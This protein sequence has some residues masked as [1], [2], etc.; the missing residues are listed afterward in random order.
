MVSGSFSG[1]D[2]NGDGVLSSTAGEI[3]GFTMN[4]SVLSGTG[5]RMNV[6]SLGFTDL[7]GLSYQIGNSASF[8]VVASAPGMGAYLG[9]VPAIPP[10]QGMA[11]RDGLMMVSVA[12][13]QIAAVAEPETYALMLAGLGLVG[14]MARRHKTI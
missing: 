3:T 14:F 1:V 2:S 12:P 9:G 11:M 4:Y 10:S 5:A 7:T 13:V 8:G 6:F